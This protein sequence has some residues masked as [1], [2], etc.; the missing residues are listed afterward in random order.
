MQMMLSLSQAFLTINS[1][2]RGLEEGERRRRGAGDIFFRSEDADVGFHFVVIRRELFVR[3][4]P[5]IAESI[6]RA[7]LKIDGSKAE[8]DAG[9]Q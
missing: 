8:R 4:G 1:V 7:D 2:Q 5:I 9:P 6:A 3:D